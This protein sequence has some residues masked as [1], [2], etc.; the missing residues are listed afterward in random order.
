[1]RQL[2]LDTGPAALRRRMPTWGL[3]LTLGLHLLLAASWRIAHPPAHDTR[4]ERVFDLIPLPPPRP[5]TPAPRMAPPPPVNAAARAERSA[6]APR[7]LPEPE[8]ITVPVEP[9]RL[10]ADPFA[11]DPAPPPAETPAQ[12]LVGGAK[13]DAVAIDREARKGNSGVPQNPDT[14]WG[15]F[16]RGLEGA[17]RDTSLTIKT[18]SYTTPD[19]QTIYRFRR[20]GKYFCRSSGFVRPKIGGAE[21]GGAELFD[22]RGAEGGAGQVRCPSQATWIGD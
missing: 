22:S 14:P 4:E 17:H 10:A 21:G 15:R 18:D 9:Q 12:A 2:V 1:M 3:L 20:G 6:P 11:Q 7:V 5:A 16:V 19:G 13:K 8:A